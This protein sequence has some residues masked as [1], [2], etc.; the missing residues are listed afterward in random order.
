MPHSTNEGARIYWRLQGAEGAPPIVLL[1]SIGTDLTIHDELAPLLESRFLSLRI[2]LRGHGASSATG[3]EYSLALLSRD[4]LAAMDDAGFERAIVCGTSLGGMVAM[5][6]A[7]IALWRVSGLVLANTSPAM[8]PAL[9]PERIATVRAHGVAPVLDGWASRHLSAPYL[10]ANPGRVATLERV[11]LAM[12]PRGYIGCAAAIR[13]MDVL[14]GLVRVAAP[15][16]VIAGTHDIATPLEGHGD[17]IVAAMPGAELAM[18][19]AGHLACIERP[20][21]FAGA[22]DSLAARC[23]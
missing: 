21:L 1:H 5:A 4:V 9:W 14:P 15:T 7:G 18:L 20:D 12:D 6:L 11:F 19:P 23:T 2:D 8:S 22:I 3:G 13:D 16:L 10:A 17:R